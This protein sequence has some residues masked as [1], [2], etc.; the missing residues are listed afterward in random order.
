MSAGK[1][2]FQELSRSLLSQCP[3]IL[4]SWLPGGRVIGNEF[5]CGDLS[6]AKGKSLR[7]NLTTGVF[8]DFA[9]DEKGADL[10]DLYAAIKGLKLG[11]AARELSG[12]QVTTS[13]NTRKPAPQKPKLKDLPLIKPPNSERPPLEGCADYWWYGDKDGNNLFAVARYDKDGKKTF[14]PWSYRSDGKWVNKAWPEPR[15]LFGLAGFADPDTPILIVE[16]EKT[17]RAAQQIAGAVYAVVTW[18]NGAS[19]VDKSDWTAVHGRKILIWPDADNAGRK[20]AAKIAEILINHCPQ[21]KIIDPTDVEFEGW[22]AADAADAGWAWDEFVA[23]AKPRAKLIERPDPMVQAQ[24]ESE[25]CK[26]DGTEAAICRESRAKSQSIV[27]VT[28]L[29]TPIDADA[30]AGGNAQAIWEQMGLSIA[31]KSPVINIDN[32]TKVFSHWEPLK[33]RIWFDEF[34]QQV[35][36]NKDGHVRPWTDVDD[37]GMTRYIQRVLG[38]SKM[39]ERVV[40]SAVIW[41]A[42]QDVRNEPKDWMQS[43]QWDGCKRIDHFFAQAFGAEDSDYTTAA[44][45]NWWIAMVARVLSPGCKFD[46]MVVLEGSQGE[47]KSTALDIIGGEWFM[48]ATETI[49]HKDFM[50]AMNG[51]LLIEIAELDSFSKADIKTIKKTISCRVDTYRPSYGRRSVDFPRQCVFVGSTNEDE[52]LEDPTGGRRFWPIKIGTVDVDIIRAHREQLFGEAV[53]AFKTGDKWWVMP[54]S[55]REIQESRRRSDAWEDIVL[56]WLSGREKVRLSD[57]AMGALHFDESRFDRRSQLRLGAVMRALGW[58]KR[59]TRSGQILEKMWTR[60]KD[61]DPDMGNG[62]NGESNGNGTQGRLFDHGKVV[63]NFAP[64][65]H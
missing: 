8:C 62:N 17:C 48:E 9:T 14:R 4:Y 55:A 56:P 18:S 32:V 40:Q 38:I 3:G 65:A 53:A 46:N 42:H 54:A 26:T 36:T 34:R 37:I 35:R 1:I 6:G 2:N 27:P 25:R 28:M 10:I 33:G 16:G 7:V 61:A 24:E 59:V 45:R 29:V 20:A 22:D 43:I 63:K 19:A 30:V 15:P 49:G 60:G 51:K 31:N 5:E 50:Q 58:E 44:S 21:I 11:D 13:V 52:Y 64:G 23:W 12:Q 57:V 39:T 41:F 47:F